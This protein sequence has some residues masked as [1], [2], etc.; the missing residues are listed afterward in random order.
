MNGKYSVIISTETSL[1]SLMET[2]KI[3]RQASTKLVGCDVRGV[4]GYVF[5][6]FLDE[7]IVEDVD[8]DDAGLTARLVPLLRL[9]RV[10]GGS[11]LRVRCIDQERLSFG[12]GDS[13]ELV[14]M[15]H[16]SLDQE[17]RLS[18][19]V[20]AVETTQSVLVH[21]DDANDV[22][23]LNLECS[24]IC[25]RKLQ[26][27]VSLHYKPLDGYLSGSLASGPPVLAPSNACL[28]DKQSAALSLT[29]LA[30]GLTLTLPLTSV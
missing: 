12:M 13:M 22:S 1:Q 25:C 10:E 9:E 18:C 29:L 8:G 6:D 30:V 3:C 23:N 15:S 27:S 4:C 2:N 24:D 21:V 7:F 19:A 11:L 28:A 20:T 5:D 26:Q 17:S 14:F 16:N